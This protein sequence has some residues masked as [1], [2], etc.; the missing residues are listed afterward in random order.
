[1]K[2][3]LLIIILLI[4]IVLMNGCY[5]GKF[6]DVTLSQNDNSKSTILETEINLT[7]QPPTE[8]NTGA[9]ASYQYYGIVATEKMYLRESL[10][11]SNYP[12][13]FYHKGDTVLI[14]SFVDG[15]YARITY[16]ETQYYVMV[17]SMDIYARLSDGSSTLVRESA[18]AEN[19]ALYDGLAQQVI[20]GYTDSSMTDWEKVDAVNDYLCAVITYDLDYYTAYDALVNGLAR[21]QGYAN[22][23]KVIMDKLGINCDIIYG[24]ADNG[25][26][27]TVSHAWNRVIIDNYYY[28][29]DVTWNDIGTESSDEYLGMSE[30]EFSKSHF[31][32][33]IQDYLAE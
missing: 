21:C 2:K 19:K 3:K 24:D 30:T 14:D 29:I 16:L 22:A 31:M 15:G 33:Y 26:G 11:M 8:S 12:N 17:N 18:Y 4:N 20:D 32:N 23:F 28:L 25:S 6:L 9:S 5:S 27:E 7:T 10:V 1:M 13:M